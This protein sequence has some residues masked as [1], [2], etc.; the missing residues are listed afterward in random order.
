MSATTELEYQPDF[1]RPV[2]DPVMYPTLDNDSTAFVDWFPADGPGK[3]S[4]GFGYAIAGEEFFVEVDSERAVYIRHPSW[5][6]I[7]Q[8]RTF[9][10]AY[11]DFLSEAV[12]LKEVLEAIPFERL[13][14][15]TRRLLRYLDSI[16]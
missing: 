14:N 16:V 13:D 1:I 15:N 5:S 10:E 8:G 6:L 7:G 12:E 4:V 3:S 11:V 9:D 2:S